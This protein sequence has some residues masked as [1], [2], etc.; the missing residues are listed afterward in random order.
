MSNSLYKIDTLI[1]NVN[2]VDWNKIEGEIMAGKRFKT[3]NDKEKKEKKDEM[4][5]YDYLKVL[6]P[7]FSIL[8]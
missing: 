2:N 5:N 1:Y 6:L 3:R 8:F 4:D 7:F